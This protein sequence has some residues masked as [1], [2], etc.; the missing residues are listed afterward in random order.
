MKP[1]VCP[2]CGHEIIE[3]VDQCPFC[4][5]H[6]PR[7]SIFSA[8]SGPAA[9]TQA[10]KFILAGLVLL[11]MIGAI[12]SYLLMG[13]AEKA[14]TQE[15]YDQRENVSTAADECRENMYSI[16]IAEDNYMAEYGSYTDDFEE[17]TQ[18]D[19]SLVLQCPQSNELYN[20]SVS[21]QGIQLNCPVHGAI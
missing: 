20:L 5:T 2:N 15:S 6:L 12:S 14:R 13:G 17:L 4:G 7:R 21:K 11:M 8:S 19:S 1:Q 16:L 9:G 10:K 18:F 3:K